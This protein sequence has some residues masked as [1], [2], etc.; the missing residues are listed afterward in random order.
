MIGTSGGWAALDMSVF[1]RPGNQSTFK[2]TFEVDYDGKDCRMLRDKTP[3][4]DVLG[5]DI[6]EVAHLSD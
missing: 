2:V 6:Q 5:V 3:V 1:L 4:I